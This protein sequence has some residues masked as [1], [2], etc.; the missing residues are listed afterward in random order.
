MQ[1]NDVSYPKSCRTIGKTELNPYL[2]VPKHKAIFP[3]KCT[4]PWWVNQLPKLQVV[5]MAVDSNHVPAGIL[6]GK[7]DTSEDIEA[8][9]CSYWSRQILGIDFSGSRTVL[10][11]I[12]REQ[13]WLVCDSQLLSLERER[14]RMSIGLGARHSWIL[15]PVLTWTSSVALSTLLILSASVSPCITQ[16]HYLSTLL[17]GG[18]ED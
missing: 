4:F 18:C 8:S 1:S 6:Q 15:I 3:I 5:I 16:G 7:L 17:L 10:F 9:S 2:P 12:T 11:K 13:M 14:Y